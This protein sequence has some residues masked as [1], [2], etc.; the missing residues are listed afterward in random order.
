MTWDQKSGNNTSRFDNWSQIAAIKVAAS[1]YR[2]P[3]YWM[4]FYVKVKSFSFSFKSFFHSL[5]MRWEFLMNSGTS[6]AQ[7]GAELL[8]IVCCARRFRGKKFQKKAWKG[9]STYF[10]AVTKINKWVMTRSSWHH[11]LAAV[12][13]VKPS[14]F[15]RFPVHCILKEARLVASLHR[16]RASKSC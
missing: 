16:L 13:S 6:A 4:S 9:L 15:L 10:L 8:R 2:Q 12:I 5:A 14:M 3:A 7:K 1:S 11:P